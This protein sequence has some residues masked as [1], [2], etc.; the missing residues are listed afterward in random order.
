[1]ATRSLPEKYVSIDVECVAT[2]HRHD[3]RAVAIVAV[4]D[5]HERVLLRKKVKPKEKVMSYL[6]PL[7]GLREGDLDDGEELRS[8]LAAVKSVLGP[9]LVLVG[10]GINN[11]VE[12]LK[13][14][15]GQD[16]SSTT[17]M[18]SRPITLATTIIATF[19]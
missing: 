3:D 2:G 11:D 16:F 18:F 17:V 7:T 6:T 15:E 5:Q 12:W 19:R 9:D 13:L 4:V 10:Q 14:C 8:V 1:M